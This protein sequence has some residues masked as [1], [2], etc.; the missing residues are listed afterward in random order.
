MDALEAADFINKFP[1]FIARVPTAGHV[2]IQSAAWVGTLMYYPKAGKVDITGTKVCASDVKNSIDEL[3]T[4]QEGV[5]TIQILL[6]GMNPEVLARI[7]V[8]MA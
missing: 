4:V 8:K 1:G 2:A 6:C 3:A 5:T 7:M